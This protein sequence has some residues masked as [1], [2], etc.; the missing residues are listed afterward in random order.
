MALRT[1]PEFIPEKMGSDGCVR[2][3]QRR[4]IET[5]LLPFQYDRTASVAWKE[6]FDCESLVLP[7]SGTLGRL[8]TWMAL[9]RA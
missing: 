9:V 1:T 6:N 8:I 4:H 5:N 7:K 2:G 3:L